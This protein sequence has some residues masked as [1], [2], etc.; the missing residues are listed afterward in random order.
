MVDTVRAPDLKS[1][2][3]MPI[4]RHGRGRFA[5]L[6]VATAAA[7]MYGLSRN[8]WANAYYSAA[9]QAGTQSWKAFLFG[10]ADGGNAITVD[11]PPASLWPME[12]SARI[13][14]VNTWSIQ[15]PQVLIGVASVALLYVAVR[16]HFGPSA[17]LIAGTALALTPVATLMFRF[18]NPDAL[19]VFLLIAAVWALAQA[20]EDGRTRWIV[21]CGIFIGFGF[22]TKQLQVMLIVPTLGLTYWDWCT[23]R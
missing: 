21:L 3:D 13:F 9:V 7:W 22:L 6:L 23:V 8:G 14:G 19:L 11:K 10:S 16:K 1:P 5:L 4:T 2:A 20:L 15:I 17:G 12:I 18:N